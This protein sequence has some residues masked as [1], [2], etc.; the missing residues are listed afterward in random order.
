M[1]IIS[2]CPSNTELMAYLDC[3]HMLVGV[4]DYSDWPES[5]KDL[6]R[7]GPDL[8]INMN[9]VERLQPDLVVAS[10]SVPGMERN[11]EELEKRRISHIVLNPQS[12]EDISNDLLTLAAKLGIQEKGEQVVAR[13]RDFLAEYRNISAT[14]QEK[15]T[16]YWEWWPKP[17]FSPG[18]VN[19][20]TEISELAGG[21]NIFQ[22]E[23]VASV[24]TG[25][26]TIRKKNPA[27]ICLAW[28]GVQTNK[29]NPA[30][31]AKREGWNEIEAI[32]KGHIHIMEE[33]LY[34]R[35]SPRLLLGLKKVAALIHPEKYP[36]N[37]G[38]DPLLREEMRENRTN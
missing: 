31:V 19:W 11:I 27:H 8:C 32:Q 36:V 12:L 28:V 21:V 2:I 17:V 15:Q 10:L 3:L 6:P 26:E 35:P 9:L 4:D 33:S 34:C 37:D 16:L 23:D 24:Q 13:Y 38:V 5:V 29:M 1:R 7:L 25:W 22:D 14:I 18:K 30:I 20:L